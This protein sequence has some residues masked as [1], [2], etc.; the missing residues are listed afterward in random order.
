MDEQ[1]TML[2]AALEKVSGQTL[3]ETLEDLLLRNSEWWRKESHCKGEARELG[4]PDDADAP[5]VTMGDLRKLLAALSE[6][7]AQPVAMIPV[8]I[9][10][11]FPEINPS[12]YSHDDVCNLNSW[13]VEVVL[14]AT[15][16]KP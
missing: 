13:G 6:P 16:P 11:R 1:T 9:L 3:R 7:V 5:L 15:E 10:D 2:R 8:E 12:N 4:M 14:A